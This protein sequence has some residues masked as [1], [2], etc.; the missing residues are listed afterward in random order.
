MVKKYTVEQ[1]SLVDGLS[2][3]ELYEVY[4]NDVIAFYAM[5]ESAVAGSQ[6]VD[7]TFDIFGAGMDKNN[8]TYEEMMEAI[9]NGI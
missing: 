1:W 2:V 6:H 8:V 9:R 5:D 4:G 7:G 3:E